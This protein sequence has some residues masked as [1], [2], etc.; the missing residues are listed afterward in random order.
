MVS[1]SNRNQDTIALS[2]AEAEYIAACEVSREAVWLRK[3]LFDLFEGPMDPTMI[4]CDS[5]SCIRLSE[6]P[7]FHGNTKHINNKYHYI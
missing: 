6:D 4:D 7:M 1:R 5:T 2:S 3:L